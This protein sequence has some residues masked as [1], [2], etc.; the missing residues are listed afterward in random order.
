MAPQ[1]RRAI[2]T[3]IVSTLLVLAIATG[4][5]VAVFYKHLDANL[6]TGQAIKHLVK[7]KQ[8][9]P[10]AP[11]NI[12]V[13]GIDTRSGQG[14][15]IDTEAGLNGSDTNILLHV[16]ADRRSAY[17]VSIA[18]DTLVTR[19]DCTTESGKRIPGG[20]LQQ[21]NFAYAKGGPACTAEQVEQVTGVPVDGYLTVDFEGFKSMVDA[22]DGVQVCI[23]QDVNDQKHGIVLKA[24]TQTLKGE[25][26][27][28]YVR[29]RYSTANSDL[30]RMKRQ[31][32]FISSMINKVVSAGTLTRPDRLVKFA[33][34]AASSVTASPGLDTVHALVKLAE[35]LKHIDLSHITFVTAPVM[36]YP[37]NP[38]RLIFAP[39]AKQLWKR[40]LNDKPLTKALTSGS[41]SAGAPPGGASSSPSGTASASGAP[42]QGAGSTGS[43][44]TAEQ[45]AENGL[46]S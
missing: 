43:G 5:L 9:G 26:A 7:K 8:H 36:D 37:Q 40:I 15:A 28:N 16:S 31:Q 39:D 46:C 13:M 4:T 1:H 19:P 20:T 38:N 35:Q 6:H 33:N 17:G 3:V 24:G 10:K 30:G 27:L 12:L 25:D 23:P 2:F 21:W 34:A 29:E 41:I 44:Q 14:D 22:I 45:A 11:L 32:A 18:R 42:S